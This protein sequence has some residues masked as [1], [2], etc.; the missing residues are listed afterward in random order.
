MQKRSLFIVGCIVF[1]FSLLAH[2]P[3]KLVFPKNSGKFQFMGIGGSLW[4]GEVKQILFSGKALPIR[5]LNWK[6][7]P[8]ALLTGTL[9]ADFYEQQTPINRGSVG[10][11]LL[12]RRIELHELHW[13]ASSKSYGA[14]VLL[15]DVRAWGDLVLD[16]KSLQ[17]PADLSFPSQVEGRL[18][19][20][21]AEL[22]FGTEHW[23]IGSPLIQLS[24]GEGAIKGLAKN[25]QPMLPG[26]ATFQCTSGS[27]SINLNLQPS[28]GAP[29]SM[30]NGLLLAG[31]QQTG[32]TFS[33]QMTIPL[34]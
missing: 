11:S 7:H 2:L 18:D 33:G 12:S 22:Q 29:Q 34:D 27:C 10:V 31:L 15:P 9:E 6:V 16:I 17:I 14:A 19:W 13:Q 28:P 1:G 21:N 32:D 26:D 30:L 20:Q 25:S 23:Q 24:G 3:A 4:Q 8:T 5:N